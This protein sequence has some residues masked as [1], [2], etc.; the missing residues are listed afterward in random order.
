M[1]NLALWLTVGAS[2]SLSAKIIY[3][4]WRLKRERMARLLAVV[5]RS[6]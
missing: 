4:N 6:L 3:G 2:V 1:P 5:K